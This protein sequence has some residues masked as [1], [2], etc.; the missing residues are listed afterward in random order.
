MS[1]LFVYDL[2]RVS[3]D[4]AQKERVIVASSWHCC[5]DRNEVEI[6]EK[7]KYKTN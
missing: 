4:V 2:H 3:H 5:N 6:N 7:Q 1:V